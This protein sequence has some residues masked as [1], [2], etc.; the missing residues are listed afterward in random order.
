[1]QTEFQFKL[2][3]KRGLSVLLLTLFSFSLAVAQ[4]LV[5][6]TVI[7]QTG[8]SVPG[9]SI[10]VK[11]GTQGTI[12]DLDGKFSLNVPNKKSVLVISFIGYTTQ[13]LPV[14]V[15][16]PMSVVLKEDTKTLD[17]V[18]VVGYQE[19]KKKDLTGAV[20]KVNMEDLLKTPSSSF[21]Q[22][23]G[24]RIAGV[25]V[26]SG[27]GM[28]GGTMNIVIRGNNS[29]T[30]D[31]SP[32]YVIDG[33]PVEDPAIAATINPSDV[34]SVDVLKDASATAIYGARGAN[35]VVIMTT[36]KG[37][38]GKPQL[39]Y[40]GS[41]GVQKV[42][43]TIPMMDAYEFV[44][45]QNEM[46][47]ADTKK[48]YLKE[49][50]GKQWTL[51]DYR[52][53]AQYDWQDEIFRTAWQQSH[54]VSLMGGTEG[55]R[56]NAS[57]SY[58]D[59]DGIVLNSNYKRFQ[60][61]MNTVVRRGKLNMSI[62]A[63]YSRAIQTGSSTSLYSSSGMNNLFYSVWGYRPVTEPDVPLSTLMDNALD[64]SVEPT[65]DYRFN[66][67]MSLK[68][69][70]RKNYTNNLQLN[71]FVEYEF[72]KGLKLYSCQFELL[73][74]CACALR[75]RAMVLHVKNFFVV[76][77]T[78]R[79]QFLKY[80]LLYNNQSTAVSAHDIRSVSSE[81]SL[82]YHHLLRSVLFRKHHRFRLSLSVHIP[83]DKLLHILHMRVVHP[84]GLQCSHPG[85]LHRLHSQPCLP[86][87]QVPYPVLL[88]VELFSENHP[89]HIRS[90]NH[91]A[92]RG[93]LRDLLP[94]HPELA[95]PD[96]CMFLPYFPV[97][98]HS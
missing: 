21:D 35:G 11:G 48:N 14:D 45:L 77:I 68:N 26:S 1:M 20:A 98:Y 43:N 37:K 24:G 64:S 44:K 62:T 75:Q 28:P 25:N 69:E 63:N 13:E 80:R 96:P 22:T 9:A 84:Y 91:P 30:Q 58:F 70:Y 56:Y 7:D 76:V 87:L 81:L 65:N 66:P 51:D 46:F 89:K 82:V 59:Q 34:E 74:S 72:I 6:G 54:N 83:G 79:Q 16:K 90:Y 4:V 55:V 86:V 41:F 19:V 17:E 18:V 92:V 42:T 52:N 29:L 50:E 95:S 94:V 97:L 40:D 38:I 31:N 32:L 12:S 27:E 39:K 78:I 33:F 61:R 10:Q 60:T 57:A 85:H 67:I 36:K 88:P 5:R 73:A 8:E 23:L 47:P 53:V 49:Y 15:S 3:W 2:S 93:L 71:G